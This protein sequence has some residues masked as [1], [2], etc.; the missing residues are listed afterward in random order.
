MTTRA[1]SMMQALRQIVRVNLD[2][3]DF[4]VPSHSI[5]ASH[6]A[7]AVQKDL[8][9]EQDYLNA[10]FSIPVE[11]SAGFFLG[12]ITVT[13]DETLD[14]L[15]LDVG[16]IFEIRAPSGLWVRWER[17]NPARSSEVT[18]ENIASTLRLLKMRGGFDRFKLVE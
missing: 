13:I 8:Y 9:Q 1:P 17:N 16:A 15:L 7:F 12:I 14:R 11:S 3:E 6:L 4:P 5:M 2:N 10:T 18:D